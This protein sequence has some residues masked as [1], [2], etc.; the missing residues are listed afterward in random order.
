MPKLLHK[1]LVD[2]A[3]I[4]AISILKGWYAS[5]DYRARTYWR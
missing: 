1:S 2:F 3:I 5:G 4:A